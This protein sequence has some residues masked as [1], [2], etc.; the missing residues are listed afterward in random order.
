MPTFAPIGNRVVNTDHIVSI[1]PASDGRWTVKLAS[2]DAISS[3]DDLGDLCS[4]IVPAPPG[5][6]LVEAFVPGP[7]EPVG[8]VGYAET[9]IV[10][11]RVPNYAPPIPIGLQGE[12]SVSADLFAVLQ[13]GG[14]CVGPDGSWDS[15][16]D[17]KAQCC[18][19]MQARRAE[20]ASDEN[21]T[22]SSVAPGPAQATTPAGNSST[23]PRPAVEQRAGTDPL[24]ALRARI[25]AEPIQPV[26]SNALWHPALPLVEVIDAVRAAYP[27]LHENGV[28]YDPTWGWNWGPGL[29]DQARAAMTAAGNVEAFGAALRF[30]SHAGRQFVQ[31]RVNGKRTSYSWK[32]AAERVMGSYVPNGVLIAA[33][34]ALG[35]MVETNKASP[36]AFINLSEQAIA[37]DPGK[38]MT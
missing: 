23:T 13:P 3:S 28:G 17:F 8:L 21:K 10:A 5:L 25:L 33:A 9:V 12:P 4:P 14:Q 18:R 22:V 32:H 38:G 27:D 16:A 35:F 1:E 19:L 11:F 6:L 31:A 26:G 29:Q 2:G 24:L 20:A 37:L 30:L 36:N 34:Y 15:L 7:S